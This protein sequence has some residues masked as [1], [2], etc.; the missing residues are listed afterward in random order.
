M[1]K[2]SI[3]KRELIDTRKNKM[4]AKRTAGGQFKEMD[5]VGRLAERRSP[6]ERQ[7]GGK[8]RA[9]GSRRPEARSPQKEVTTASPERSR[10]GY[11]SR[12]APTREAKPVDR[13]AAKLSNK[14]RHHSSPP[15]DP[16]PT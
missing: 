3:T 6:P 1:A 12:A 2:R 11:V 4:Y 8:G 10:R 13:S 14:P 7:D 16:A 5:D 15:A 9:R